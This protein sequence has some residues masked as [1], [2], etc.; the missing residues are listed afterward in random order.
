MINKIDKDTTFF[1]DFEKK[2]GKSKQM[3]PLIRDNGNVI[4]NPDI[5]SQH[6]RDSYYDLFTPKL[7]VK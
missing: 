5:I 2:N 7:I 1:F 4:D 3:T 6:V